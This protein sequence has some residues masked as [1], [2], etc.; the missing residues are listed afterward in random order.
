MRY[1]GRFVFYRIPK[2]LITDKHF[3]HLKCEAKLLNGLML[4]RMELSLQNN[5]LDGQNR[6]FIYYTIE[7]IMEDLHC[8]HGSRSWKLMVCSSASDRGKGGR[9][10]RR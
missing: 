6:V 8:G 9:I 1:N 7:S 4:D 2:G 3:E 5:W 10:Q